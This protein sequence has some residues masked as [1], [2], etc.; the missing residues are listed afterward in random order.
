[1]IDDGALLREYVQSGSERAFAE[2]VRRHLDLV[3]SATLRILNGDKCLA[4]DVCQSV[5]ID[6]AR[7]APSLL[8]RGVLSGWLYTSAC[9]AAIKAV[10]SERRRQAREQEA[11]VM[12]D[13]TR[14]SDEEVDW[15]ELRPVLDSVMLE[16]KYPDQR[17]LLLRFFE[18]RSL[19]E[20][21]SELG[22]SENAARMR[23]ER[24]LGRLRER[25]AR[26]GVTS[27]AAALALVLTHQAVVAAPV[28]L[29]ASITAGT[30]AAAGAGT[31]FSILNAIA[32]TKVKAVLIAALAT[33]GITTPILVQYQTNA[34]LKAQ[35]E[36]LRSQQLVPARAQQTEAPPG[37]ASEL[38]QLRREHAELVRLRGEVTALRQRVDA[39]PKSPE[40]DPNYRI[41]ALKQA[42]EAAEAKALLAKSP[43]IPMVPAHQWANVGFASPSAAFETFNWAVANRDTNAFSN[44]LVWDAQAKVRADTLFAA[45]PESVRQR[46]GTVDGVIFDWFLNNSTPV[47]AGRVLSQ[48]EEGPDEVTL[49]EQHLYNDGRVR[50]N[51]V[52]FQRDD[53]GAWRQV[54]PPELMPKLGVVLNNLVAS[55]PGG[56]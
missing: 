34:R 30:L 22:L 18:R 25:L 15:E 46:Y 11:H 8:N 51:T 5:F 35:L 24:A 56:R 31:T 23:V 55:P 39:A 7:K 47:A 45:A 14:N 33:A 42:A 19:G 37:D 26:R 54:V 43:E 52:Q 28:G 16:L 50:E 20:V 3:Y 10:R 40:E 17:V 6:L 27:S 53:T 21:G 44:A 49:V 2:L 36:S 13:H 48:V 12:Q 1:M 32:M 4:E 38:G 29:A 41:K 9:F